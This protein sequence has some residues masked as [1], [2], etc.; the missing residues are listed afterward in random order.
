MSNQTVTYAELNLAKDS[1]RQQIKPKGAKSSI[2]VT[3]QEITYAELNLQNASHDLQG[4]DKNYHC[5]DFP[6]PPEKLI[7]GILGVV[8]LVLL[9]TVVTIV[10]IPSPVIP[11][12]SNSSP[13]TRIEKVHHCGRCPKE[14]I[15][16]SNNCYYI[17]NETKTW[18]ESQMACA[19]KNSTLL[20]IDDE[21]EKQF[22]SS[23]S[24]VSWI[25]VFRNSSDHQWMWIN[26]SPSKLKIK[27]SSKGKY[28]CAK[29]NS[30]GLLS[31]TC[32]SSEVYLCKHK[33][34]S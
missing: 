30:H 23:L 20:L 27:E 26:G 11:E 18:T 31:S 34:W 10:V 7:A 28:N 8:C 32:G 3:E 24:L 16:Y 22:L 4:N 6:S 1:R 29:L 5:K 19:S 25:G 2:S 13:T 17:S 9:S 21:E 12:Q 14:W 15:T 33:L